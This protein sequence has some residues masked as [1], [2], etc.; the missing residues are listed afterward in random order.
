MKENEN[1]QESYT[2]EDIKILQ[3]GSTGR[4]DPGIDHLEYLGAG[5][6]NITFKDSLN[7]SIPAVLHPRLF[8]MPGIE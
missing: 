7:R 6:Y 1:N 2:A 8:V 3:Y 4:K 5:A